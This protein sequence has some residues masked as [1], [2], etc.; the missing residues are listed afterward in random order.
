VDSHEEA[1]D[2]VAAEV[3]EQLRN[4][5]GDRVRPNELARV[6]RRLGTVRLDAPEVL[7]SIVRG[8]LDV[9]TR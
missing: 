9:S 3:I 7:D 1:N 5:P 2:P 6:R 4:E 8:L